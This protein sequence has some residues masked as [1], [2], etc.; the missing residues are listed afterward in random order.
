MSSSLATVAY[1][2]ATIL[3]ILSLGGLSNQ[4]TALRGNLYGMVGMT[5]AVLATVLGPQVTM[6]GLPWIIGAMLIG[7]A[8]GLY[9]AKTVQMTQMPELVALMHSMV[10]LA[11]MLVGFA[12]YIDPV[13]TAEVTGA[14]R[15]IHELEIYVGIF[16]GAVTFSGSV[17]AFGKLSGR[18]SGNPML[19]P[20][21]HWLNL[22]GL[23]LVIYFGRAFLQ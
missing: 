9:A 10:G 17:I 19:L 3:F 11:A 7:G 2:G 12:T 13:A 16:I 4:T 21:R 23:L 14:A 8:I 1:I 15:T 6:A 22:A 20:G 18:V 5:I